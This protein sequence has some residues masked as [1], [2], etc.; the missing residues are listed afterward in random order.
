MYGLPELH[1]AA[2][3]GAEHV[4]SPG[5]FATCLTLGLLPLARAGALAGATVRAV[6]A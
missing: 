1:R 5:C 6:A 4:A 3:R 2:L